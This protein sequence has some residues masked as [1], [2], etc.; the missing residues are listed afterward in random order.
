MECWTWGDA[1]FYFFCT[2]LALL[3]Y[4]P[5]LGI[6]VLL[7][8][9]PLF[10]LFEL[11]YGIF[12]EFNL[13]TLERKY[14]NRTYSTLY[15]YGAMIYMRW[16]LNTFRGNIIRNVFFGNFHAQALHFFRRVKYGTENVGD[17]DYKS[18]EAAIDGELVP[19]GFWV[20]SK[21]R[22]KLDFDMVIFFVPG[23]LGGSVSPYFYV[24]YLSVL[25]VEL[26]VQGFRNPAVFCLD[27][28]HHNSQSSKRRYAEMINYVAQGWSYVTSECPNAN[29]LWMGSGI[30]GLS[31]LNLLL[32]IAR[33]FIEIEEKNTLNIPNYLTDSSS[34]NA[35][36][37]GNTSCDS[38]SNEGL[39]VPSTVIDTSFDH[40][41]FAS[42]L[43]DCE[44]FIGPTAL[45]PTNLKKPDGLMLISPVARASWRRQDACSDIISNK[46]LAQWSRNCVTEDEESC[47]WAVPNC[48]RDSEWWE[49]AMPRRGAVLMYGGNETLTKEIEQ[50]AEIL[51][52]VKH[53][54]FVVDCLGDEVH[55]WPILRSFVAR[56]STEQLYGVTRVADHI[57]KMLVMDCLYAA[58]GC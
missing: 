55:S 51:R 40:N 15:E 48:I 43:I 41:I 13:L 1:I 25:L 36:R 16:V 57:G 56:T 20:H 11:P 18:T 47:M 54:P 9:A 31:L 29:R 7:I 28:D 5:P 46:S 12:S 22:R 10:I 4:L 17:F 2:T 3:W 8:K 34:N 24:E 52:N 35:S 44:R 53:M 39:E 21:S 45:I 49:E 30:G 6:L 50:L 37:I 42:D 58:N 38:A 26:Q 19:R 23:C 27:I 32:H 14:P 33:P